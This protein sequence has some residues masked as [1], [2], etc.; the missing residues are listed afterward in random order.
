MA[1]QTNGTWPREQLE[2][3]DARFRQAVERELQQSPGVLRRCRLRLHAG[4]QRQ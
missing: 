3:M 1:R 4:Y 2:Q